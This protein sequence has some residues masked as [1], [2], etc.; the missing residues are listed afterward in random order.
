MPVTLV[1][2]TQSGLDKAEGDGEERNDSDCDSNDT[3]KYLRRKRQSPFL[4]WS[5]A[6]VRF[7]RFGEVFPS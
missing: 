2:A 4:A 1:A 6:N 3:G 7:T 5:V